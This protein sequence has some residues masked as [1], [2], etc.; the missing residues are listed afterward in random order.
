M[1]LEVRV[2]SANVTDRDGIKLLLEPSSR[3][4]LP[5][6]LHVWLDSGYTGQEDRGAGWVEK[7]LGWTAEIVRHPPKLAPEEVM[8]LGG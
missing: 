3:K 1:V 7:T 6:L 8:T 4:R 2:H 5:R